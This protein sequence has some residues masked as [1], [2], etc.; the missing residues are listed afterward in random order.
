M[1]GFVASVVAA[2]VAVSGLFLQVVEPSPASAT[3][4]N[5]IVAAAAGKECHL[6]LQQPVI[7]TMIQ[8]TI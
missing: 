6:W 1:N 5:M 2:S 4:Q 8:W 3:A 7:Q